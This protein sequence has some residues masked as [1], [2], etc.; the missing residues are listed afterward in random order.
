MFWHIPGSG[1]R[2][3]HGGGSERVSKNRKGT[4]GKMAE[5]DPGRDGGE[6]EE[7]N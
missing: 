2:S 6:E 1:S 4:A 3:S 5:K 7:R